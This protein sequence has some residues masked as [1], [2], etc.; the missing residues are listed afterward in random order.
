M[1]SRKHVCH[2]MGLI[3]GESVKKSVCCLPN[4]TK[5]R[6]IVPCF[7]FPPTSHLSPVSPQDNRV[8]LAVWKAQFTE[9]PLPKRDKQRG[10]LFTV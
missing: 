4:Q 3:A 2:C 8:E 10:L 5:K 9:D 1:Y 6:E 7:F